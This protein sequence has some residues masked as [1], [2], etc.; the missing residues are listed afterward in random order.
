M[1]WHERISL[2]LKL[3]SIPSENCVQGFNDWLIFQLKWLILIG[4]TW[5]KICYYM[6]WSHVSKHNMTSK[7]MTVCIF[8][9]GNNAKR[10][11]E[12]WQSIVCLKIWH[13]MAWLDRIWHDKTGFPKKI[14]LVS[15]IKLAGGILRCKIN[16]PKYCE[17]PDFWPKLW[18]LV[19]QPDYLK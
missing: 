9:H 4:M 18:V 17:K 15:F 2:N 6:T 14:M 19:N 11:F 5:F 13:A 12:A 7:T 3:K 10:C 8:Y 1:P 16:L